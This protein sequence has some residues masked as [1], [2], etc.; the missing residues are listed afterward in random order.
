MRE[1]RKWKCE[2][3]QINRKNG[4]LLRDRELVSASIVLFCAEIFSV[5]CH[6][7]ERDRDRERETETETERGR[8]RE[9]DRDR[10]RK[11]EKKTETE[12]ETETEKKER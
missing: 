3:K 10:E 1:E 6:L 12:T 5:L 8:E 2:V 7:R 9:E 11:R 4:P